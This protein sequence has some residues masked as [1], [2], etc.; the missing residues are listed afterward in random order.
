[1]QGSECWQDL[2][3]PMETLFRSNPQGLHTSSLDG[4]DTC[5]GI[6]DSQAIRSCNLHQSRGVDKQIRRW[7][8]IYYAITICY[9]IEQV[10]NIQS[11]EYCATVF[12][13]GCNC[14]LDPCGSNL[15]QQV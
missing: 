6:F 14:Y 3:C 12:A 10:Q 1:M 15:I 9:P 2:V 8:G 7:F 11:F 13:A 4:F 5:I